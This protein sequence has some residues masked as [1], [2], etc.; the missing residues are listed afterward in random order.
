MDPTPDI[1]DVLAEIGPRLKRVRTQR[2]VTLTALASET[3]VEPDWATDVPV[4]P[5]VTL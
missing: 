1:A 3:G 5:G 2:N 4:S